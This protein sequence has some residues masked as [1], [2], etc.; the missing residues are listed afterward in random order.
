VFHSL[1]ANIGTIVKTL[2][3]Y[4]FEGRFF[5]RWTVTNITSARGTLQCRKT[6]IPSGDQLVI[7]G[8]YVTQGDES[9]HFHYYCNGVYR[10]PLISWMTV[11]TRPQRKKD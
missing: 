2:F 9:G 6:R 3:I 8:L 4:F 10:E 5:S 11:F 7:C 1:T